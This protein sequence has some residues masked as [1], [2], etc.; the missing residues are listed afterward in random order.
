MQMVFSTKR[1][2]LTSKNP[3]GSQIIKKNTID[4]HTLPIIQPEPLYIDMIGRIQNLT[5]CNS[6]DK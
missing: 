1:N 2:K 6:C 5:N 4:K 3:I